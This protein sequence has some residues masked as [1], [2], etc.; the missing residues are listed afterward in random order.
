MRLAGGPVK[1]PFIEAANPL[2][3]WPVHRDFAM[4]GWLFS[5]L[6]LKTQRTRFEWGTENPAILYRKR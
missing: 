5:G 6:P 4:S 3:L 2:K 1:T